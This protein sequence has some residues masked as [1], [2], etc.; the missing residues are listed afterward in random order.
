[1]EGNSI[2][3]EEALRHLKTQW[4]GK[5]LLISACPAWLVVL[6]SSL[7]F[8][9][10]IAGVILGEY[11]RRVNVVGE[12]VSQKQ[13]M[14]IYAPWQGVISGKYFDTGQRVKKG[15]PLYEIDVSKTTLNGN[16]SLRGVEAIKHQLKL[17]DEIITTINRNK[18]S[19]RENLFQQLEKYKKAHKDSLELMNSSTRGL[20][21]MKKSMGNYDDYLKRGLI[22]KEQFNNQRYLFYQ[23]QSAWQSLNTQ[24]IQESLQIIN[25]ETE[26]AMK[27]A[28]FDNQSAEYALKRSELERQLAEV[29][30]SGTLIIKAPEDGTIENMVYTAGQMVSAGD[31]LAQVMPAGDPAFSLIL[32]LTDSSLPYVSPGDSVNLRFE[33]YPFEKFGQFPGKIRSVSQIPAGQKELAMYSSSMPAA[34]QGI[35]RS[36]YKTVVALDSKDFRFQGKPMNWSNGMKAE[37]TLFLESRPLYQWI[38]APYYNIRRS[39]SGPLHE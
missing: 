2:F 32:W 3:R 24:V 9:V 17:I 10:I 6:F 35:T 36:Y 26:I 11:T 5:A 39:L 23:Q 20:Q 15:D 7:F 30:A 37:T 18:I 8:T 33:A 1:M 34:S 14:T 4:L 25:L 28:D 19:A 27:S 31:N 29:N 12:I 38:L 16:V 13:A 22:N 21:D